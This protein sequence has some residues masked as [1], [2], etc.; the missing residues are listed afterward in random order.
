MRGQPLSHV[1]MRRFR[2]GGVPIQTG[3]AA[4]ITLVT[5]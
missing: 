4:A 3:I 2:T 1:V 5:F